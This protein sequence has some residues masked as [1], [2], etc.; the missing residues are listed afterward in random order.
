MTSISF[1]LLGSNSKR[2]VIV[3]TTQDVSI[4]PGSERVPPR[5]FCPFDLYYIEDLGVLEIQL[6]DEVDYLTYRAE[7]F[8]G[9]LIEFDSYSFTLGGTSFYVF[10]GIFNSSQYEIQLDCN[11]GAYEATLVIENDG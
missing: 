1:C 7:T 3:R 8:E 9:N 2:K 4:N 10:L 11:Y 5:T 6:I